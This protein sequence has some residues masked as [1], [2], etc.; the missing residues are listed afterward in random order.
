MILNG[1]IEFD[2]AQFSMYIKSFYLHLVNLL[3]LDVTP[4]LRFTLHATLLRAGAAYSIISQD[5]YFA[6]ASQM[7]AKVKTSDVNATSET[8]VDEE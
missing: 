7:Q 5:A 3:L 8:A 6:V 1:L 4:E 2:D